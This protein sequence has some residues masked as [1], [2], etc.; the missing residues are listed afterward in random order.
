MTDTHILIDHIALSDDKVH[1]GPPFVVWLDAYV[2]TDPK[3]YTM[4]R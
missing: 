4:W 3:L 1:G 2:R